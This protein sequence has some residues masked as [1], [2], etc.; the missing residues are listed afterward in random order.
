VKLQRT[1]DETFNSYK[2]VEAWADTQHD[3]KIKCLRSDR[4]GEFLSNEFSVHLKKQGTER[5]LTTHDTPEHNG[6]AEH[7]NRRLLEKG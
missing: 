6:I 1:K 2:E 3:L 4:G 7:V 5:K